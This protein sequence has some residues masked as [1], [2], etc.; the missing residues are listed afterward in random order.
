MVRGAFDKIEQITLFLCNCWYFYYFSWSIL[1]NIHHL[2]EYTVSDGQSTFWSSSCTLQQVVLLDTGTQ[3]IQ[4]EFLE[5]YL[6]PYRWYFVLETGN[7]RKRQG[8]GSKEVREDFNCSHCK[9]SVT[10]SAL[11]AGALSCRSLRCLCPVLGPQIWYIFFNFLYATFLVTVFPLGSGICSTRLL[12]FK[13]ITYIYFSNVCVCL[14]IIGRL[15]FLVAQTL[16]EHFLLG[17]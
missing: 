2:S 6:L 11:C 13:K 14:A 10:T 3:Q 9:N 16:F 1:W 17:L 4:R 5:R 15:A 8:L 12:W 7:N